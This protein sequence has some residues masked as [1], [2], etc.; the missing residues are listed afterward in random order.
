MLIVSLPLVGF[1]PPRRANLSGGE[2]GGEK[3]HGWGCATTGCRLTLKIFETVGDRAPPITS[4]DDT[5]QLLSLCVIV[6]RA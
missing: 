5:H 1:D 6:G 4:S 2:I 3:D